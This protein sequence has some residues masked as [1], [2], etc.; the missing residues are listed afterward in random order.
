MDTNTVNYQEEKKI[1]Y[2]VLVGLLLLTAVTFVQPGLF[3]THSTFLAQMLIA[4]TKGWLIVM[5]YMHLKGE[6]LIT[7]MVWFALAL[8]T[9]FFII[10]IGIDV[11]NFQFGAESHITA[12][13]AHTAHAA[14]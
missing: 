8:V 5:Y 12:P 6:K 2:K 1:Y 14:H 3:M 7:A 10:V 9:V 11:V 4:V 13:A